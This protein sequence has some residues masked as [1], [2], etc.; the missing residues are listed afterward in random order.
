MAIPAVASGVPWGP[1]RDS[2]V[3]VACQ[4]PVPQTPLCP[5]RPDSH[6]LLYPQAGRPGD[7][8]PH[9]PHRPPNGCPPR[10]HSPESRSPLWQHPG[11]QTSRE[12]RGQRAGTGRGPSAPSSPRC[13][14]PARLLIPL[15][16]RRRLATP[17]GG[18]GSLALE[19]RD[20][21]LSLRVP[22]VHPWLP[23]PHHRRCAPAS[24][25]P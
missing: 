16:L 19:R 11:H 9:G 22:T 3:S 17:R 4:Q 25:T 2:A 13:L 20:L 5:L 23:P 8:L 12:P 15:L 21:G 6:G 7:Q 14:S 10:R 1:S 24:K 18:A